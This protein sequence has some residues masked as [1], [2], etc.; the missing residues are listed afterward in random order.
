MRAQDSEFFCEVP[1]PRGPARSSR[2]L[3]PWH[4]IVLCLIFLIML[5]FY[6]G[7]LLN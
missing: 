5:F 2:A 4:R 6:L 3:D 1:L 7:W